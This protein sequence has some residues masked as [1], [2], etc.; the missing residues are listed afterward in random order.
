MKQIIIAAFA[1]LLLVAACR[2]KDPNTT[3]VV[4]VPHM[5]LIGTAVYSTPVGSGGYSDPGASF[6]DENGTT[7]TLTTP[8]S[9]D[10]DL[11]TPGFYSA[12][13]AKRT[14]YG[15]N[16][17][18]SRLILV[19]PVSPALDYSGVYARTSNGQ[20]VTI[21]KQGTGLYTTDNVGGVAGDDSYLFPIYFGMVNDS[22][23]VVPTQ[24]NPIGDVLYCTNG[25]LRVAGPDTTIEWV[26]M[27]AGFGTAL[28]QFVK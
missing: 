1:G 26:V 12:T 25:K 13:Y 24:P 18:V 7:T 2:K 16:V 27:G 19:T 21:T 11:A 23:I 4:K 9:S 5:E 22:D 20:T 28:R 10:V 14:E 3:K 15:Y 8:T 17:S 6:T